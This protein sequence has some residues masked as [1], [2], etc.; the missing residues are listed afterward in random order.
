MS[1]THFAQIYDQLMDDTLY[2]Q[3]MEYVNRY[4]TGKENILELGC[5][6]GRLGIQLKQA[7]YQI[8]GLDQSDNMLSLAYQHQQQA[9]ISFP[10]LERDMRDLSDLPTYDAVISFCD[11]LCYLETKEDVKKVFAQVY[12]QLKKGG[13]FLFDVHSLKQIEDFIGYSYHTE[14]ED[15]VFLWES[16]SGESPYSVEHE[17]TIFMK[18]KEGLYSRM[19][20]WHKERTYPL[21]EYKILLKQAGFS[22]IEVTSDFTKEWQPE[23]KRWFFKAEK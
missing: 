10:L 4:L 3:W 6:T 23:S 14:I 2:P 11:S 9:N 1:Y 16:Y 19:D 22:E 7:G 20:E 8:T 18:E 13:L 5:G 15:A 17:L 21:E 12:N